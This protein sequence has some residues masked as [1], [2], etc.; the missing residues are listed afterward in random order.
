MTMSHR[1]YQLYG[2][3]QQPIF[4]AQSTIAQ[5]GKLQ[6]TLILKLSCD[7]QI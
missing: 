7:F 6:P 5:N 4:N 1:E 3:N 2:N